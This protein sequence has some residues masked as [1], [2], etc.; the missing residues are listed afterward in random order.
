MI[1]I[2]FI[3]VTFTIIIHLINKAVKTIQE[4]ERILDMII[5]REVDDIVL[6]WQSYKNTSFWSHFKCMVLNRDTQTLY[7]LNDKIFDT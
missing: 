2:F 1:K 7:G 6:L 4:R 3:S 5:N